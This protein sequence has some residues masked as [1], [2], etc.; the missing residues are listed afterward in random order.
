MFPL[1]PISIDFLYLEKKKN[2][3]EL[4]A[5]IC[6]LENTYLVAL[7]FLHALK[8]L[9]FQATMGNNIKEK[10]SHLISCYLLAFLGKS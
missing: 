2:L 3:R 10:L 8:A 9:F 1:S 6:W 5:V 4:L 7:Q